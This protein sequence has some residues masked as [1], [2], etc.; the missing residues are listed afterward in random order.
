MKTKLKTREA[1]EGIF[2]LTA[3]QALKRFQSGKASVCVIGLGRIGLPTA[4]MFAGAGLR[5]LGADINPAV[6]VSLNEGK[7]RFVDEP[8]LDKLV[9]RAVKKGNLRATTD[10]SKAVSQTDL[11]VICVPTPVDHTKTPDYTAVVGASKTIGKALRS[12]QV[13]I[14]EST[15][16]PG[17]V[18]DVILPVL[19]KESHLRA[20]VDFGLASCPER[21][22]PGNII[23]NMKTV[24]RVIGAVNEH[25]E[26]I[27]ASLYENALGVRVFRAGN[28]KTANAIKLTENLFRD[29]NIA[30]ANEFA[31]LYEKLGIDAIEVINGC[32]TKYNFMP[33]YPGAGVGGPC[34]VGDE[35]AFLLDDAG[36]Q[37]TKL[38]EYINRLI[39]TK[40]VDEQRLGENLILRPKGQ[41]MAL[42]FNGKE[43]VFK[44]VLWLS[45]RPFHGK[46][47][48]L[49]LST[50]RKL[51][52]TFDHPMLIR[53]ARGFETRAAGSLKKG[54][55]IPLLT[56]YPKICNSSDS[57]DLIDEIQ[58]SGKIALS[59]IKA[60]PVNWQIQDNMNL[61]NKSLQR[62][63][64]PRSSRHEFYRWNYLPL[65]LLLALEKDGKL[66]IDRNTLSLYTSKGPTTFI[67]AVM[68]PDKDFWR[69]IG[70]YLSE[71]CLFTE[72]RSSRT[73]IKISF[74]SHEAKL[75]DDCRS[76]LSK[77]GIKH[78]EYNGNGAH[79]LILSSRIL[80]FLIKDVLRCGTN[81][82]N[83]RLPSRIFFSPD[84]SASALLLGLFRGDGWLERNVSSRS[85][86]AGFASVS[87]ELYQGVLLLL[88]TLGIVPMCRQIIGAKSTTPAH[89]L[90]ISR[91]ED[92]QLFDMPV[93]DE[94]SKSAEDDQRLHTVLLAN[95][96]MLKKSPT[97]TKYDGYVAAHVNDISL[98]DFDGQVYNMEIEDTHCFASSYGIIT[99][100]C[101]PSNSYYLIVEG[102][103]SGNIPYIIRMARE[104]NDRMPD[105][106][107]EL[108]S[109][110][111]NEVG[112][113]ARGSKIAILGVAYK[114]DIK[115]V[116]LSPLERVCNSLKDLGSSVDIYDPMFAGEQVFSFPVKRSLAQAVKGADCIVV[117]TAHGEFKNLDL[118]ALSKLVNNPAAFVDGRNVASPKAVMDAGFAYRGVGRKFTATSR[119][120]A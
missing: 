14:M 86:Q 38:G 15:V 83:K 66:P 49:S 120:E 89:A 74:G 98:E 6:V 97:L 59:E 11:V 12:G 103:K 102:I 53:T 40:R 55:E 82:Y 8:G 45:V 88:G 42:S 112:K 92:L 25:S 113:T 70:Y 51:R 34:L 111:L 96:R 90:R 114:P 115:D 64:V 80:G 16:G 116:Q 50:G 56:G 5:V 93:G 7:C 94:F 119:E 35:F 21:S 46:I 95:P 110:A 28:P 105:H 107:V 29:V 78:I 61:L 48:A 84:E 23:S 18:E 72:K 108:V 43:S 79:S 101:L 26:E 17:T 117:G 85:L 30:L 20:G 36:L 67:P 76:I 22:D 31:L 37:V 4:A 100:N 39:S 54:E 81:S 19:E 32:A 104:I 3:S 73:R 63:K 52:V 1:S 41:L 65:K 62:L 47:A 27:V 69:F 58:H 60:K 87:A 109:E 99:H 75:I 10:V 71:G 44:K 2:H 9:L 118:K 24:P 77:W 91:F 33:H 13:V 106:V 68:K 57:I